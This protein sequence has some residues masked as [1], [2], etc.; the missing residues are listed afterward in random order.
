MSEN[1]KHKATCSEK[2]ISRLV[3]LFYERVHEDKRLG[4]IFASEVSGTWEEHLTK[5]K[6]FWRSVLLKTREYHGRPVPMHQKLKGIETHDF[7][8]WLSIFRSTACEVLDPASAQLAIQNSEKIASSLWLSMNKDPFA[9]PPDWKN[10]DEY[11][12]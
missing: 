10:T 4:E 5:M 12:H 3:E 2:Q 9:S 8:K 11:A 6:T 7:I 1:A